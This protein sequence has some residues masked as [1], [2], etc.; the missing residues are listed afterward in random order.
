MWET[1]VR[2]QGGE[3]GEGGISIIAPE[4]TNSPSKKIL[5]NRMK[6]CSNYGEHSP[7]VLGI[8]ETKGSQKTRVIFK[9]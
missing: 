2:G 7:V 4:T 3:G 8:R 5:F 6:I 9:I 1:D